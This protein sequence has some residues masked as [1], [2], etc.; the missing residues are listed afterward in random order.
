MVGPERLGVLL[1][2]SGI[3]LEV[4]AG[5]LVIKMQCYIGH[6]FERI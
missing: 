5:E 4:G 1:K 6:F 2:P 3:F